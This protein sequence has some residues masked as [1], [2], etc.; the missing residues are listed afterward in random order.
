[1]GESHLAGAFN[2]RIPN[3]RLGWRLSF[4]ACAR[5]VRK[6]YSM[7]VLPLAPVVGSLV[8]AGFRAIRKRHCGR[9]MTLGL[10]QMQRGQIASRSREARS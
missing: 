5:R 2:S 8:T 7:P 1:M 9:T 10:A 4:Q 6:K 3:T